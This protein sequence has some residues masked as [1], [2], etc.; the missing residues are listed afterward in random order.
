MKRAILFWGLVL[1][2]ALALPAFADIPSI[3]P[4]RPGTGKIVRERMP[5]TDVQARITGDAQA[6]LLRTE[7]LTGAGEC[8]YTLRGPATGNGAGPVVAKGR[9][10]TKRQ[11]NR[12]ILVEK[13]GKPALE[14]GEEA[15]YTLSV[16]FRMR[17][18]EETRFGSKLTDRTRDRNVT[19]KI[20]VRRQN[21]KYHVVQ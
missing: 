21:G 2:T 3:D 18:I 15:R 5:K 13:L 1:F 7:L 10:V 20:T 12:V 8:T 17:L 9:H 4:D 6:L 19:R 16:R 11:G 14:E